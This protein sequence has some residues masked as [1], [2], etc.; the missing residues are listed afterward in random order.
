MSKLIRLDDLTYEE[1]RK[2]EGKTNPQKIR[3]LLQPKTT[4]DTT[5]S[6]KITE[7]LQTIITKLEELQDTI[8][9]SINSF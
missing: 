4:Q 2:V 6:N 3:K 5:E 8:N 9:K 7:L 1:L